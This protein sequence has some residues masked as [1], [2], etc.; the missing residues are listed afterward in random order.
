MRARLLSGYW[1]FYHPVGYRFERVSGH[2]K[3]LI[4][5]EPVAS[6]VVEALE[7]FASG[8]FESQGE[9]KRFL[10]SQGAFPKNHDGEVYFQKVYRLL[11]QVLYTGTIDYPKWGISLQPGKHEALISF[12]TYSAIQRRLNA[13]AQAPIRKDIHEDF[14]LR[15]F[16]TCGQC[17]HPLSACW[18]KGRNQKYPYYLCVNK[19]CK[20]KGKSVRKELMEE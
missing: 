13:Q 14:P 16:V 3:I 8:R 5:N 11:T 20:E 12:E 9:V 17:N 2:G 18:S 19:E 7:G 1:V 10:D 6:I 4:R 15:G